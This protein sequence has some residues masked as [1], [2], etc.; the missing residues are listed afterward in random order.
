MG[1]KK[2]G[3]SFSWKRALG[4]SGTKSRISR[5]IGIPLTRSG[6]RKK[7]GR[8]LGCYI[9][10]ATYGDNN[11]AQ[12]R[13]FYAFRDRVLS[14]TRHGR[15]IIWIYYRV[16]PYL[17]YLITALPILKRASHLGLDLVAKLID[18]QKCVSIKG[19]S[20]EANESLQRKLYLH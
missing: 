13:S 16:S 5:K 3:F 1:R 14:K 18:R 11:C 19:K 9:A 2:Y 20:Q 17:A 8:E 6:R 12:V 15:F 7:L 10:T 4:I